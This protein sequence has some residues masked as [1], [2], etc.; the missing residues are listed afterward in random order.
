MPP[1]GAF[2]LPLG[3]FMPGGIREGSEAISARGRFIARLDRFTRKTDL[4]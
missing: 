3:G 4:L 2:Y 1:E